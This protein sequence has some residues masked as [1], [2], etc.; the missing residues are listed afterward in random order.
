MKLNRSQFVAI[1]IATMIL[2]PLIYIGGF[3][4]ISRLSREA[5][6]ENAKNM[7]SEFMDGSA[8]QCRRRLIEILIFAILLVAGSGTFAIF[9]IESKKEGMKKLS[10][11]LVFGTYTILYALLCVVGYRTLL[12]MNG[13]CT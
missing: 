12:F 3:E 2:I 9:L 13:V 11:V 6:I 7:F 4:G 5:S 10:K 1:A 8:V